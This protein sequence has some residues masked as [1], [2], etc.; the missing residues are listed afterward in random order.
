MCL[1]CQIDTMSRFGGSEFK[2]AEVPTHSPHEVDPFGD[3]YASDPLQY[4]GNSSLEMAH[5]A[6]HGQP[7]GQLPEA[8]NHPKAACSWV[9]G[10]LPFGSWFVIRRNCFLLDFSH[11]LQY[12]ILT[13]LWERWGFALQDIESVEAFLQATLPLNGKSSAD[14]M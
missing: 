1:A 12:E 13:H 9:S 6:A 11:S 4:F 7:E 8:S 5:I 2:P 14:T 3:K 10:K